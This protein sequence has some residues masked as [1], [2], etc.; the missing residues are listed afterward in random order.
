MKAALHSTFGPAEDVLR[1]EELSIPEPAPGEVLV[2][3]RV[4]GVNPSDWRRRNGSRGTEM[5]YPFLVV[6]QDGAGVIAAVGDA[7]PADRL[8]E[9]VWLYFAAHRRQ[10]GTAA[11]F[12][13]LPAEQA[14]PLPSGASFQLGASLGIPALTAWSCVA[15]GAEIDG[16]TVLV[17]GGAGAVGHFA[18]ELA[19]FRGARVVA[20]ASAGEKAERACAAG[21]ELVVD[22]R[23]DDA[24][25]T[26]REAVPE[27][28]DLIVEV[29]PVANA[30]L[31]LSVLA[32][33]GE[34][35]AYQTDGDLTLPVGALMGLNAR[36]RFVTVFEL[37]E[38]DHAAAIRGVSEAL[39]A[40]ALTLLPGPRFAL[41]EIVDAHRAAEAS[42]PGKVL[43]VP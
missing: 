28:F 35:V 37:G 42:G 40:G 36:L 30:E 2:E 39:A 12:V 34:I 41:A 43:V 17:Q 21:A 10:F 27:G 1:V 6:G 23:R 18:I 20:T 8:G 5:P 9:R 25:A 3:V 31:D 38:K 4:S 16:K 24:S 7:V 29:A 19:R 32:P 33:R 15:G 22:P 11:E 26:L 13:A 14:I